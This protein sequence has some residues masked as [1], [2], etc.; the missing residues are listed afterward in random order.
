ME[1]IQETKFIIN[2]NSKKQKVFKFSTFYV[3]NKTGMNL[4]MKRA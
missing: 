2:I 3:Q 4:H 1:A